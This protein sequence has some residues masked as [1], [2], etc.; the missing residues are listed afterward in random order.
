MEDNYRSLQIL[1]G[2][3]TRVFA[4]V[5]P[6]EIDSGSILYV[7]VDATTS[8]CLHK[9]TLA[10][11]NSDA[12]PAPYSIFSS[13]LFLCPS[14]FELPITTR[15]LDQDGAGKVILHEA[16]H[17]SHVAGLSHN[18]ILEVDDLSIMQSSN[19]ST[20][21]YSAQWCDFF[22]ALKPKDETC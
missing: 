12:L 10:F 8:L 1:S 4:P 3:I 15:L 20:Y 14:F 21:C 5:N 9:E 18:S 19:S 17:M 11:T 2:R 22:P 13:V 16:R 7:S 6:A